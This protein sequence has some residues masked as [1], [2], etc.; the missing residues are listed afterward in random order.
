ML[1]SKKRHSIRHIAPTMLPT[2]GRL[3]RLISL[4]SS[5]RFWVDQKKD[6][7]RCVALVKELSELFHR[8]IG[9]EDHDAV[10]GLDLHITVDQHRH[11]VAHQTTEGDALRYV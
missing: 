6:F 8:S 11:T 9:T 1:M 3:I 5:D 2:K 7:A 10:V 4:L